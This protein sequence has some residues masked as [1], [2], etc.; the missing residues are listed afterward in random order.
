MAI[1]WE[2]QLVDP[3]GQPAGCAASCTWL[4]N[5]PELRVGRSNQ[6]P[7]Q[8]SLLHYLIPTRVS[9][10][11]VPVVEYCRTAREAAFG[12]EVVV[13]HEQANSAKSCNCFHDLLNTPGQDRTGDLQR[14]RLTS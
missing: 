14:V 8:P 1:F 2:A 13:S 11:R 7:L 3:A 12:N 6:Y 9:R 4:K 5:Q 10:D